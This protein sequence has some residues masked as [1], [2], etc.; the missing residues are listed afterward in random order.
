MKRISTAVCLVAIGAFGL[1]ACGGSDESSGEGSPAQTDAV[2]TTSDGGSDGTVG[3]IGNLPGVSEECTDLYNKY[4]AALGSMGS[5]EEADISGVFTALKD[6]LPSELQDD[7]DIV[8]SAWAKY[9]EVL[10]KYDGDITKAMSDGDASEVIQAL[11]DEKVNE[12]SNA[13]GDY[14][15]DTCPQG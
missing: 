9:E 1:V 11:S 13:I 12:A 8:A 10:A 7:A 3:T 4:I 6:V 5:G 2:E 15:S 14:F